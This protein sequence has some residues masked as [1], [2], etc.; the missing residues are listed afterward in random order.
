MIALIY[1][2]RIKIFQNSILLFV[3]L[4]FISCKED[5]VKYSDK[6][7]VTIL[8]LSI[9]ELTKRNE[10][11][12]SKEFAPRLERLLSDDEFLKNKINRLNIPQAKEIEF[13][14]EDVKYMLNNNRIR[15]EQK[16]IMTDFITIND[17]ML[18]KTDS[19]YSNDSI[20]LKFFKNLKY[21]SILRLS[22]PYISKNKKVAIIGYEVIC[23]GLC[24]NGGK[25]YFYKNKS[26]QW[27]IYSKSQ[28]WVS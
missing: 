12:I 17:G 21:R 22:F 24:G 26:N 20:R 4:F 10:M 7:V 6:D 3:F 2:S 1:T 19:Y 23:E 5:S 11:L 25:I 8:N 15:F 27:V 18:I 28:D 16:K 13:Y 9:K 14:N